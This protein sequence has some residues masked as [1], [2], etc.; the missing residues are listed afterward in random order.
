MKSKK[1]LI[2]VF[3]SILLIVGCHDE[4]KEAELSKRILELE[5]ELENC[6]NGEEQLTG[7]IKNSFESKDYNK[8]IETFNSFSNKF[9]GSVHLTSMKEI[10]DLALTKISEEKELKKASVKKLILDY[11]D[12]RGI[13]W[14]KQKYFNHFSNT[15]RTSIYIGKEKESMPFLRLQM[16]YTG[17]DWIF[18]ENAYLSFDGDTKQIFFDNYQEKKSDN[19]NGGVWEWIDV[20][21]DDSEV[22][23]LRKFAESKNAKMRLSGKYTKDRNLTPQERQ[24]ILDVLNGYQYLKENP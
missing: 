18:F 21:I 3:S 14:Y 19:G 10:H 11:D 20:N 23:W 6:K 4:R 24:G 12:V 8:V 9:P 13:S 22:T 7:L 17:D 2:S 5:N 1:I 16:S 15:N